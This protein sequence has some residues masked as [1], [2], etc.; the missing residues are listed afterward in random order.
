M[1]KYGRTQVPLGEEDIMEMNYVHK[2]G[3]GDG[4]KNMKLLGTVDR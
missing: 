4:Q 2:D 3:D 1:F